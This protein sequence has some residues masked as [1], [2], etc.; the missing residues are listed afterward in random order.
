MHLGGI[1]GDPAVPISS[2][3]RRLAIALISALCATLAC[4]IGLRIYLFRFASQER[5]SKYARFDDVPL[6]AR[7][8]IGHPFTNYR[9]NPD[10][11]SRDGRSR[12]DALGLRGPE[13]AIPKPAGT[14]RIVCIGGSTTYTTV[15]ADSDTYPAQ[16]E[17]ILRERYGDAQVEVLNAGVGGWSSWE[18][19]IDLEL[20]VIDLQPDLLVVYHGI[21]DVHPRL[22]PPDRYRGDDTGLIHQWQPGEAWWE[23]SVLLRVL[24]VK[25]GFARGNTVHDLMK[26]KYSGLDFEDCLDRNPPVYFARN[27]ESTIAIARHFHV[28]LMLATFAGC[29]GIGDFIA[30][31]AYQRAIREGNDVIRA[32]ATRNDVP[33]LEF[34][35]AMDPDPRLWTDG[36]HVNEKG[37][38]V[39][40]EIFAK[41]VHETFFRRP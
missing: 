21:N 20:R 2:L 25:L 10:Y 33:L 8:L 9:L 23:H 1:H 41:F 22:V 32:A 6:E 12:H 19:L 35:T 18:C 34:S 39:M 27:L 29:A 38:K 36:Q 4:E 15:P 7:I 30:V 14:Y 17:R 5:L 16:L 37:A 13:V 28:N 26:V 3:A 11:R 31:P 40:A 24:G